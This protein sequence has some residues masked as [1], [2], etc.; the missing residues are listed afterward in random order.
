MD[1]SHIVKEIQSLRKWGL[2]DESDAI[3][4]ELTDMG[5]TIEIE[6]DGSIF[7]WKGK[8][9]NN[10]ESGVLL[11]NPDITQEQ[12]KALLHLLDRDYEFRKPLSL[13]SITIPGDSSYLPKDRL[14]DILLGGI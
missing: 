8:S 14:I 5:V 12:Q 4:S 6:R 13:S 11:Q 1:I 9:R 10:R 3:R 7:W 2:Y